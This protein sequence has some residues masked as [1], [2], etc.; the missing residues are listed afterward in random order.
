MKPASVP[1]SSVTGSPGGPVSSSTP[2]TR[3]SSV[4][5]ATVGTGL[6][7]TSDTGR[8][9]R[10][11]AAFTLPGSGSRSSGAMSARSSNPTTCPCASTTGACA[12]WY[13]ARVCQAS[14]TRTSGGTEREPDVMT[15]RTRVSGWRA[16]CGP[17]SVCA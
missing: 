17:C 6:T 15:S 5:G 11:I 16:C 4:S 3:R 8:R 12:T 2:A 1:Y 10:S 7:L 9:A 13:S 14:F